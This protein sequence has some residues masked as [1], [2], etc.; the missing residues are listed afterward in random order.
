[1]ISSVCL[2]IAAEL[3]LTAEAFPFTPNTSNSD[4]LG[5]TGD[6]KIYL[7]SCNMLLLICIIILRA[8]E[9]KQFS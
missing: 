5:F 9:T 6:I 3:F 2:G 7:Q 4:R 1:M 8:K